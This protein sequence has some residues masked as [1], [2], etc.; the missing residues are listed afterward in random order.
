MSITSKKKSLTIVLAIAL[1]AALAV[2]GTLMLFTDTSDTATNVVTMGDAEAALLEASGSIDNN[3]NITYDEYQTIGAIVDDS[4]QKNL[5]YKYTDPGDAFDGI[6]FSNLAPGATKV[7]A[8]KV[9]NLTATP[10]YTALYAR[11]SF[12]KDGEILTNGA[13]AAIA[14]EAIESGTPAQ[15]VNALF[16]SIIS[17]ADLGDNW[18]AGSADPVSV[19]PS[20]NAVYLA[21]WYYTINTS[22]RTFD[23]GLEIVGGNLDTTPAF[24]AIHI[25]EGLRNLANNVTFKI[26]LKAV[27]L[28]SDNVVSPQK[29]D[30]SE[31]GYVGPTGDA[32]AAIR[33]LFAD[34]G[35]ANAIKDGTNGGVWDN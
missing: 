28:Q 8:P 33:G 24:N 15:K 4:D 5:P 3:G 6:V 30:S 34:N 17:D 23:D 2:V 11:I 35:L 18:C 7:K 21:E 25:P 19:D 22:D 29:S 12:E 27:A 26:E 32:Y 14:D 16:G 9:K 13:I 31:P 1:V 10:F 20:A